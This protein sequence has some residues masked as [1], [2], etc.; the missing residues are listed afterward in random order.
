MVAATKNFQTFPVRSCSL[1]F[2]IPHLLF[3]LDTIWPQERLR[4]FFVDQI[5][6]H[7]PISSELSIAN[8]ITGKTLTL[9]PFRKLQPPKKI[10]G[11]YL[12]SHSLPSRIRHVLFFWSHI[13]HLEMG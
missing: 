11:F 2:V 8:Y 3:V 12:R 9:L 4:H 6:I 1:P 7:T 13:G 10:K 5:E